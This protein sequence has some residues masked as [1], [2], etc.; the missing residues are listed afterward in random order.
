MSKV[1]KKIPVFLKETNKFSLLVFLL[2]WLLS[3]VAF[4][5]SIVIFDLMKIGLSF[6]ALV[7]YFVPFFISFV[8]KLRF[9]VILE[10]T[11]YLFIF[12]SLILG[13]VFAFYGPFPFWDVI[14]HF[15]SGF[16]FAGIGLSLFEIMNKGKTSNFLKIIFAFCFSITLGV[17]WECVEFSFDMTFRTDAQ[18]DAH[19]S[20]ISTI[21]MQRDGGNRPVQVDD[22]VST[23]I[24]LRN[25]DIITVDEG[26][27][28]IGLMDTMKDLLVNLGGAVLFCIISII[29]SKA[30]L[31]GSFI[32]SKT[33][34]QAQP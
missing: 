11:Y 9:L 31:T 10:V 21:T 22:I 19:L 17:L 27:L 3:F 5:N 28:D 29:K 1:K 14:L 4:I 7:L 33:S 2:I 13:E 34:R 18:K 16:V 24:R 30:G 8:F 23:D 20:Q 12:A 32:T 6:S 26:F 25:G 15:L